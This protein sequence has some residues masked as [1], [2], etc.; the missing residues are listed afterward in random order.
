[1]SA[2]R[3]LAGHAGDL[4]RISRLVDATA[5]GD[6]LARG[7]HRTGRDRQVGTARS[8]RGKRRQAGIA[9]F[10]AAASEL[11]QEFAFGLAR[12][13][14]EPAVDR[15]EEREQLLAGAA[16]RAAPALGFEQTAE[17]DLHATLHGLYWLLVNLSAA[18]PVLVAVDDLQWADEPS[19]RWLA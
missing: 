15:P 7:H 13:L 16:G 4:D 11:E 17:P 8:R 2:P 10:S 3:L 19:L 6:G 18:G 14:F 1:M 12:S 5:A 9:T